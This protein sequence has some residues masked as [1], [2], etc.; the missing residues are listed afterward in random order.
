MFQTTW[1]RSIDIEGF[2]HIQKKREI[3]Y[4][5]SLDRK[6]NSEVWEKNDG[7]DEWNLRMLF[8]EE[9]YEEVEWWG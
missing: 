7:N 9:P 1:R 5:R 8:G 3:H 4:V 6:Y 2:I